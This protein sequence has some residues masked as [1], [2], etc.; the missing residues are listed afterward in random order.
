MNAVP[1]STRTTGTRV[2]TTEFDIIPAGPDARRVRCRVVEPEKLA[3]NAGLVMAFSFDR[4]QALNEDIYRMPADHCLSRGHR[5]L[6]FDL[7]HHGER[8]GGW[9]SQHIE[10]FC[11]SLIAGVDP[12]QIF[13]EDA[14]AAVDAVLDRGL[15]SPGKIGAVGLSRA[16]YCV[17]RWLAEDDRVI[18]GA[19]LAPVT[20]WRALREFEAV[21]HR[22]EVAALAME[23]FG[24]K[25]AGRNLFVAIGS[26][27]QRVSTECC[28]R[29]ITNILAE[30]AARNLDRSGLR[31]LF[32]N[33]SI[34]HR[35]GDEWRTAG[36]AFV[37]DAIEEKF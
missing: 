11:E 19:A 14:R 13:I 28:S 29:F 3:P 20:D 30:E 9:K 17:L 6:S 18:A 21:K 34:G 12:F 24:A 5:V 10:G 23:H 22:P 36:A 25:L 35:L 37:V 31:A 7:P 27:D 32:L 4:Q 1:P 15:A 8:T 16:G 2:N 33:D 26:R